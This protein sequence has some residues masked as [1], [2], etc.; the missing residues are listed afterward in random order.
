MSSWPE[1][2]RQELQAEI[3]RTSGAG[4]DAGRDDEIIRTPRFSGAD[5]DK[6][7]GE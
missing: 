5:S 2:K 6:G 7:S 1:W 3:R 4:Q